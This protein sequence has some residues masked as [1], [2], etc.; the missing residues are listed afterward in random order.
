MCVAIEGGKDGEDAH[1]YTRKKEEKKQKKKK[2]KKDDDERKTP[3]DK[4]ERLNQLNLLGMRNNSV[5]D[6]LHLLP[7]AELRTQKKRED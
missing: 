5:F 2:K 6:D 3:V 7:F 1:T 4:H